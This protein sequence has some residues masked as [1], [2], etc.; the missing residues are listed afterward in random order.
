MNS[1]INSN[2]VY[3]LIKPGF[4]YYFT[5]YWQKSTQVNIFKCFCAIF[6]AFDV[7]YVT[8]QEPVLE[9]LSQF[10]FICIEYKPTIQSAI[11]TT[12]GIGNG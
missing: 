4:G 5:V 8:F 7:K 3:F 1:Y 6:Y 11:F 2:T 9:L 10:T 12:S